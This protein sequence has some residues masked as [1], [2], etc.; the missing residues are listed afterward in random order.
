MEIRDIQRHQGAYMYMRGH[1]RKSVDIRGHP[2]TSGDIHGYRGY[3]GH[4]GTSE[5]FR[6]HMWISSTSL[7]IR[8]HPWTFGISVDIRGHQKTSGDIRG[9]SGTFRG[10]SW[11]IRGRC[12]IQVIRRKPGHP[13]TLG[14]TRG[15][16]CH[17][18]TSGDICGHVWTTGNIP[19]TYRCPHPGT[20]VD[21]HGQ[22]GT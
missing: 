6:G 20:S 14:D 8:E 21:M 13:G 16:P 15:N 12:S 3:A 17:L 22:P 9:H 7:G 18:W 2:E 19:G 5:D 1:P 10:T 4:P 11:D